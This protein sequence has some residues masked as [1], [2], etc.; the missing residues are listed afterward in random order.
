MH[1]NLWLIAPLSSLVSGVILIVQ[2]AWKRAQQDSGAKA[3]LSRTAIFRARAVL[4][5]S[6]LFLTIVAALLL[7]GSMKR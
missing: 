2:G 1:S 5:S 3:E 4:L 7:F 6:G